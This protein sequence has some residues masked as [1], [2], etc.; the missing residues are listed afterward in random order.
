MIP[1]AYLGAANSGDIY[2]CSEGA[3]DYGNVIKAR[4]RTNPIAP[5][6]ASADCSFAR[7]FLTIT[8]SMDAELTIV[9]VLDDEIIE[10]AQFTISC[11][12]PLDAR[13]QSCVFKYNCRRIARD[14][15][16]KEV[17]RYALRGTWLAFQIDVLANEFG[18]LAFDQVI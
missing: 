5:G 16:D 11:T 4:V 7:V 6:G 17:F 9:P 14:A 1:H 2:L 8:W 3:N 15:R 12:K 10:D 18:E 13:R